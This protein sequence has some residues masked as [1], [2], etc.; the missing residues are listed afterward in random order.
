M[1]DVHGRGI[2]DELVKV[3]VEIPTH[4]TTE[5]RQRIEEFARLSGED[6]NKDS[7]TDKIKK[8]FK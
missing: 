3:N 4:L 6:I 2:G 1:P 7:F 8:A 5:Q